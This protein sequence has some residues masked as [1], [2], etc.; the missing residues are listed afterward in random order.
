MKNFKFKIQGNEYEVEIKD[1]EDNI[2]EVEVNG[3][4]YKVEVDKKLQKPKTPKIVSRAAT[5][6]KTEETIKKT[7]GGAISTI[8]SPLPGNILSISVKEGD[9]IA[10][11]DLLMVMEAMKM[12]NNIMAEKGGEVKAVKVAVGDAVL[13]GDVLIEIA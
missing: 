6:P 2:A 9:N 8:L 5:P 13:Q 12:E 10:K 4:V 1:F 7:T 3:S 11:G